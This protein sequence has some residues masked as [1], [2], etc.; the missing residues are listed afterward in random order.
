[1]TRDF[2]VKIRLNRSVVVDLVQSSYVLNFR[3]IRFKVS[4]V[5]AGS[6]AV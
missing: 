4:H 2:F 3:L 1:M 6:L 5:H